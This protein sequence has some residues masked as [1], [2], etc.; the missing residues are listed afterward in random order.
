MKN[1]LIGYRVMSGQQFV[2]S[3]LTSS[4]TDYSEP[5]PVSHGDAFRRAAQFIDTHADDVETFG[6]PKIVP[7]HRDFTPMEKAA[8]ELGGLLTALAS[9]HGLTL[10]LTKDQIEAK[11]A[12]E[13]REFGA[14]DLPSAVAS[15]NSR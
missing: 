8:S 4:W 5:A 1:T 11:I 7:V 2:H 9:R 13:L 12:A 6:A 14:T 15:L 3:T 10:N